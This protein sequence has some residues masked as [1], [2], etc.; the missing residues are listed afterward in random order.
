LSIKCFKYEYACV[1]F[2]EEIF[3]FE[4]SMFNLFVGY[5]YL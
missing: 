2:L 1:I 5:R 3:E 4:R